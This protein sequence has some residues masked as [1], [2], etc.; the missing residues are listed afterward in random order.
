LTNRL[1]II[2]A[3]WQEH[4][5]PRIDTDQGRQAIEPFVAVAEVIMFDNRSSL[6]DPAGETDAEAW[7]P[8]GDYLLELRRRGKAAV[9]AHHT[10]RQGTARGLSRAEDPMDLLLKLSRP[11]DYHADQGARFVVEVEKGRG[12]YGDAA[13]SFVAALTEAGWEIG[14]PKSR[15]DES[16]IREKLYEHLKATEAAG[17]PPKSANAAIKNAGIGR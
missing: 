14:Q 15:T 8:A 3:D 6:F 13:A 5:M 9:L 16:A 10:N 11:Q 7:Q 12:I 1:Q 2:A 17:E 4:G